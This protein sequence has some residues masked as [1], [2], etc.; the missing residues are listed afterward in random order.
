MYMLHSTNIKIENLDGLSLNIFPVVVD[1][2]NL[3]ESNNEFDWFVRAWNQLKQL[4][5]RCHFEIFQREGMV[6]LVASCFPNAAFDFDFIVVKFFLHFC[7][8]FFDSSPDDFWVIV[9]SIFEHNRCIL[10]HF[11]AVR[12][13]SDSILYTNK[14]RNR[15]WKT[16]VVWGVGSCLGNLASKQHIL[17]NGFWQ[18]IGR[19]ILQGGPCSWIIFFDGPNIIT[20]F[21]VF[22][23]SRLP[24]LRQI[25]VLF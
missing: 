21:F 22:D 9:Q 8:K 19:Q 11:D 4:L 10:L 25:N 5:R 16:I 18:Q 14:G 6:S 23:F 3:L 13:S 15:L 7:R 12:F 17:A 2:D 20:I 1:F 24:V